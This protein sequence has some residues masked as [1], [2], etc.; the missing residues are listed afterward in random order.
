[1]TQA[2]YAQETQKAALEQ[3]LKAQFILTRIT[4]DRSDIVK[5]GS[6]L[7]LQ[8]NGLQMCSIEAVAPIDNSYKNGRISTGF[9]SQMAWGM[10]LG[11]S[12][13]NTAQI[14]QRKFVAGEKFWFTA[15]GVQKDGVVLQFYSDPY[16]NV[17]YYGQLKFSYPKGSIP[18]A[19]DLMKL[20]AEAVTA[21]P[22]EGADQSTPPPDAVAQY[23]SP[24]PSDPALAPV[25]PPPP[26]DLPPPSPKTVAL[27]QTADQV[28]AVLGS[29]QKVASLGVREIYYY[30]DVKVTLVGGKV[31]DVQ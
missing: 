22:M 17:R 1:M 19:D 4:A 18:S 27:G 31:T 26:P 11:L 2:M 7:T 21:E 25:A 13:Q 5:A 28:T 16:D 14:P 9:G 15:Y 10:L 12:H 20:I 8:K 3:K 29:P 6:I 30:P 23:S 24:A